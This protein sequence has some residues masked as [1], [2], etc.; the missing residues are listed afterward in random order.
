MWCVVRFR[1]VSGYTVAGLG[2]V[3]VVASVSCCVLDIQRGWGRDVFLVG[4]ELDALLLTKVSICRTKPRRSAM[5]M[6]PRR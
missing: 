6:K 5:V 3:G 1:A 2:W 4:G